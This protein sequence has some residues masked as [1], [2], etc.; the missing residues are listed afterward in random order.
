[1]IKFLLEMLPKP[2]RLLIRDLW[3]HGA[4]LLCIIRRRHKQEICIG[5]LIKRGFKPAPIYQCP[6]CTT[7]VI[8]PEL[9]KR[10]AA[11]KIPGWTP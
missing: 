4:A 5:D 2:L 3:Y 6:F 11:K 8:R 9:A 10:L 7:V 1:M